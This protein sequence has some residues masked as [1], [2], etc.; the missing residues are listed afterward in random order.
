M[1]E[2]K[3]WDFDGIFVREATIMGMVTVEGQ[4][5]PGIKVAIS[6]RQNAET[7][8]DANGQYTFTGLRAGNYTIE[9]SESGPHRRGILQRFG[10]GHES[11]WTNRRSTASTAR[12]CASRRS[13]DG[14]ASRA[15]ASPTVTVSLQGE[16]ENQTTMTDN[17]GQYTFS[18]L[19][20]GNF[21]VGIAGTT[22]T[23]TRSRAARRTWHSRVA[24]PPPFLFEGILF[25]TAVITW[26]GS[27]L[28]ERVFGA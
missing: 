2:S 20:A 13:W 26:G 4:G 12:T 3:V 17:S 24:R 8:T 21:Q 28:V 7:A 11:P 6:G 18:D 19:P 25:K 5:L 9:I 22:R 23:T 1:G 27:A 10:R 16:G 15:K 14:S